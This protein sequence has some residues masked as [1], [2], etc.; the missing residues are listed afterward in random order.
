MADHKTPAGPHE[1]QANAELDPVCLMLVQPE[2]ARGTVSYRGKKY[3]FCSTSCAERFKAA[4]ERFLARQDKPTTETQRHGE[5][6]ASDFSP[7]GTNPVVSSVAYI[8]PMDPEVRES[9]PGPCPICG[10]ALEAEA[11]P[12]IQYTCPMHPE[13]VR[14]RPG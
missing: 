13:V 6:R 3:F 1:P 12:A 4:P 8:C 9:K 5:N 14:D 2:K 7:P 10:M 11:A